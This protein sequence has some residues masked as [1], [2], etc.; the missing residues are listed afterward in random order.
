VTSETETLSG[1][2]LVRPLHT[3]HDTGTRFTHSTNKWEF[4]RCKSYTEACHPYVSIKVSYK[5]HIT[6]TYI[7]LDYS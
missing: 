1:I 3:I 7:Y 2:H 6:G 4:L 5:P